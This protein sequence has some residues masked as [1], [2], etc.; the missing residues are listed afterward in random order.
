MEYFDLFHWKFKDLFLSEDKGP[1]L[2][3]I[4]TMISFFMPFLLIFYVF[5]FKKSYNWLLDPR[6]IFYIL[7]FARIFMSLKFYFFETFF[8]NFPLNPSIN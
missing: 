4:C 6:L 5:F 1:L 7:I 2:P 8:Y 3:E